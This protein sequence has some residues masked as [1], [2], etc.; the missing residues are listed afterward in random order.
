MSPEETARAVQVTL[1]LRPLVGWRG[2]RV[3]V[4]V[5]G[6][7]GGTP[8]SL[9]GDVQG[10]SNLQAP[11]KL[12]LEEVWLQQNLFGDRLSWLVGRYDLN[13]EFY[14]LQSAALFVN[15]SFGI[16]PEFALSGRAGPSIFPNT[17]LGSR[18]DFKPSP[19]VVW[20]AAVLDGVPVD[21]AG[22]RVSAVRGGRRRTAR[23]RGGDRLATRH[24]GRTQASAVPDRPWPVPRIQ[25]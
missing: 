6:T 14:R 1:R 22:R 25:R 19:N 8:S 15:S 17:S 21:S 3:F 12:R 16:G 23:R 24:A 5:L 11:A 7:H 4:F 20:R 10:V 13:T 9:V 18:I 2:A